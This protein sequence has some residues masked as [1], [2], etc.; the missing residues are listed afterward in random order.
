[1]QKK[2]IHSIGPALIAL[3]V[4]PC[5]H[6]WADGP[7][8]NP[9]TPS[10]ASPAHPAQHPGIFNLT[11]PRLE[12]K[13]VSP[14]PQSGGNALQSKPMESGSL[15]GSNSGLHWTTVDSHPGVGYQIDKNED[16]RFRLGGH[17][18][19]ASYALHF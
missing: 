12:E 6:A 2:R 7:G 4:L 8:Q 17:G 13:S 10:Q 9:S 16:V 3:S 19:G 18:A 15:N 1:M 5:Q 11:L 14:S